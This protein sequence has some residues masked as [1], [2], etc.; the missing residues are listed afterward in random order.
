MLT[1]SRS[2][3]TSLLLL[4]PQ[5]KTAVTVDW[6]T[7]ASMAGQIGA[8]GGRRVIADVPVN[9]PA[10]DEPPVSRK[11]AK[12]KP[13]KKQSGGASKASSSSAKKYVDQLEAEELALA[14]ASLLDALPDDDLL[15]DVD[16]GI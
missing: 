15:A 3:P 8:H 7:D 2:A 5:V 9:R 13:A 11:P 12:R 6:M 10:Y 16:I 4:L 1:L 14:D